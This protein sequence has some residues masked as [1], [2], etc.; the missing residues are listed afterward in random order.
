MSSAKASSQGSE[1]P[2]DR[3]AEEAAPTCTAE[4]VWAHDVGCA[5]SSAALPAI[6]K[7]LS[8]LWATVSLGL[9]F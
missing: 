7:L 2:A 5:V 6:Q 1:A 9:T 8:F 4:L 3:L